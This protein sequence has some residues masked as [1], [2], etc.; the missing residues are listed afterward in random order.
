MSREER[1]QYQ[2]TVGKR[3][4]ASPYP[5]PPSRR[6]G[7]ATAAPTRST[8]VRRTEADLRFTGR[9]WTWTLGGAFL[10]G[11]FV[12]SVSWDPASRPGTDSLLYGIVAGL[13][14]A[15]GMVGFRLLRRRLQQ[16]EPG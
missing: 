13:A 16:R 5:T 15:I 7:R 2:R 1:R 10:V 3:A 11:L 8:N 12:L 14:F 4:A 6:P 9:F